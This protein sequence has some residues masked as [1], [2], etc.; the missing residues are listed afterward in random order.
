ML[1]LMRKSISRRLLS[2]ILTLVML[3]APFQWL[4][5]MPV[6]QAQVDC[7]NSAEDAPGEHA[8]HGAHSSDALQTSMDQQNSDS[9]GNDCCNH[10]H[11]CSVL[12][13]ISET[14]SLVFVPGVL[15]RLHHSSYQIFL[16]LEA[17][18]PRAV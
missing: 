7:H 9:S 4:A 6:T 16:P 1:A 14:M 3:V 13:A 11:C 10:I 2:A 8:H 15:P 12:V 5:A 18:P 17:E